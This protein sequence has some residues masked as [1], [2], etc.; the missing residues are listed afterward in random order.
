VSAD[1]TRTSSLIYA[2]DRISVSIWPQMNAQMDADTAQYLRP[3]AFI[4]GN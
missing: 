2:V 1:A 4:G 3:F